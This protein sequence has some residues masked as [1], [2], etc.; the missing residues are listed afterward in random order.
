MS[1]IAVDVMGGDL[2]PNKRLE[3][4]AS[5]LADPNSVGAKLILCG[6]KALL[7]EFKASLPEADG[8]RCQIRPTTS[9]IDMEAGLLQVRNA[10]KSGDSLFTSVQTVFD[11]E[12]QA[13]V[14]SGNTKAVVMF[15][16]K[17]LG[18]LDQVDKPVIA[19][20]MPTRTTSRIMLDAGIE[21]EAS[22][23]ALVTNTFLGA[24]TYSALFKSRNPIVG[25]L[26]NGTEA[27]KGNRLARASK[28]LLQELG[29]M[30][31]FQF[32][33]FVEPTELLF[34][35]SQVVVT[36]GLTG[37][38]VVKS[39]EAASRF[40]RAEA[41]ARGLLSPSLEEVLSFDSYG[42]GL[43]LGLKDLVI[44]AHGNA[45]GQVF[46]GALMLALSMKSSGMKKSLSDFSIP[47]LEGRF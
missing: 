36:D 14:S 22:A 20:L 33:G 5:F 41:S 30:G 45:D 11:G 38:L 39:L 1:T 47:N 18:L 31:L 26:S 40:M 17:I 46:R 24:Q 16:I 7:E 34:G 27:N 35:P 15:G 44:K 9:S 21:V 6:E 13:I 37:N 43:I 42:N 19:A 23:K 10:Y 25:L 2:H 4:V 29:Q 8:L 28:D 12:A 3:G 32:R